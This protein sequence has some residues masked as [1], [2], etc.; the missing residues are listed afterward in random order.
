[1]HRY[2]L[3]GVGALV[4]CLPLAGLAQSVP[5]QRIAYDLTAMYEAVNPSIVK[6]HVDAGSGSGFLVRADGLI[7]T[8]H[9]VV[10]NSRSIAV[11][12]AD[13]RRF[14]ADIVTLDA[15]FDL[16]I[17]KINRDVAAAMKPLAMLPA[18]R[19]SSVKVGVPAVAFGSPLSTTFL[20]TQ[21]IVSKVEERVLF[22]D[23]LIK[24]GNSGGPLLNLDGEV[25]GVN[26]FGIDD[27]S[28]AVRV[29]LLRDVLARPEVATYDQPEP[30]ASPLPSPLRER[31]PTDLLKTKILNESL[32]L[33]AYR[34]DGGK[35]TI[36]ALTPV[37]IG[38]SQIQSDLQQAANRYSRRGKKIKDEKYD[39]V[40]EP[41]YDWVRDASGYLDAVVTFEIKP[42]F[43]QTAG[44][45][46][47]SVLSG[48]AAGL[49][50][51]PVTPTH[52]TMEF[53]AEFQ[54]FKLYRDGEHVQPI[55]PGRRV[56][57]QSFSGSFVTFVDEAYSGWYSYDPRVFLIGKEYKLEI[58]DARE[59]ARVHKSVV[60]D[61]DS[62][63]IQQI[64]K[65]FTDALT[66]K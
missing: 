17:L 36:T 20:M 58:Y 3:Y 21:G 41:F 51:T 44:S 32:E 50:R 43:G 8:N 23:F 26:T 1:M 64:R 25:I 38:K 16:A 14:Y 57:E 28:G 7:A 52:Q 5:A 19:D 12:L 29:G 55:W 65:D 15:Q 66:D 49:S 24:A 62:K 60:L 6:V 35:F 48:A 10:R 11:E 40:D 9:H 34:L 46:W 37:V 22:G 39:P 63:L 4:L 53:K 59:P 54:D 30:D 31:Y 33:Q 56:T 45:M 42:D 47:A 61:E 18:E 2:S 27:I 13:Q